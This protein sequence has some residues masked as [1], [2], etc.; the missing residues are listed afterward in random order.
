MA[1][2]FLQLDAAYHFRTPQAEKDK[3]KDK[4]EGK[5]R[6]DAAVAA[7]AVAA[8]DG[9]ATETTSGELRVQRIDARFFFQHRT[10]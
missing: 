6:E 8:A 7:V 4:T 2:F 10:S 3:E 1:S 5:K 9:A